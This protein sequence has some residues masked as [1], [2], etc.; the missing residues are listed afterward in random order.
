[1]VSQ[2]TITVVF[3]PDAH[4]APKRK[5]G[6]TKPAHA[7]QHARRK[8]ELLSAPHSSPSESSPVTSPNDVKINPLATPTRIGIIAPCF[9][10]LAACESGTYNCTGHGSC[11]LKHKVDDSACYSCGCKPSVHKYEDGRIL[12]IKWGGPACNKKDISIPFWILLGVT[13]F[14]VFLVTWGIGLIWG[15]GEEDLP[16]VIGA[17][18]A[19]PRATK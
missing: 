9:S 2:R 4:S 7:A 3:L 18:V 5:A 14:L 1:M 11:V 10:S 13:V 15:M 6:A 8:E 16:G 17:G 19:G 12:T